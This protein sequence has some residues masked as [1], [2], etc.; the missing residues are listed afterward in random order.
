[1]LILLFYDFFVE[2]ESKLIKMIIWLPFLW[3]FPQTEDT[4]SKK[5]LL[6]VIKIDITFSVFRSYLLNSNNI[7][8]QIYLNIH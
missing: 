7:N 3:Y 6:Y 5:D 2:A 8:A 4:S 1:M